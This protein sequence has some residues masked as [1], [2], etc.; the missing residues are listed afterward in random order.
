MLEAE[1]HQLIIEELKKKMMVKL[2][3]LVELTGASES[4][5]RRDL[6]YLEEKKLLKRVHGGASSLQGKLLEP[7]MNEKSFKNIREKR[8][9]AQYAGSL[10]EEGDTIYLD[11]GSTT[12]EMIAFLPKNIVVVTNGLMHASVL[13]EN[14]IKTFLIG[15]YVKATTK[16]MIG[17]GALENIELY[18]FDKC[19]MGVNGVHLQF[20]YT[21][22]DQEE[23]L[24]KQ[25]AF[26]LSR[27]VYVVTDDSKFS[28]VAFAKIADIEDAT[29]LTNEITEEL[30]EQYK[31]KTTIK[32][33]TV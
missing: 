23:A 27:Q 16:A 33:V 8:I 2:Q 30:Y 15:G 29:I 19:F 9:I 1:R 20:G 31:H 21:T 12:Y 24:I 3:E 11:A 22:P 28:E 4:T 32:V 13:L 5:I 26:E 10:V 18:R 7:S 14:N 17:R 25:K 6:T